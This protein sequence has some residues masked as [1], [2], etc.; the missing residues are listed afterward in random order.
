MWQCSEEELNIKISS[1]VMIS[2]QISIFD[3]TE[4]IDTLQYGYAARHIYTR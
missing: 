4:K 1:S 2:C 3:N